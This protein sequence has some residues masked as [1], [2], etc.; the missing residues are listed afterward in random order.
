[1]FKPAN[2]F[3]EKQTKKGEKSK[4]VIYKKWL[5]LSDKKL[6]KIVKKAEAKYDA[7]FEVGFNGLYTGITK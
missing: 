1:M 3:T 6:L 7:A 2:V 4:L 5:K